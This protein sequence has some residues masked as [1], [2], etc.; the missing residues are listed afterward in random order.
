MPFQNVRGGRYEFAT[1]V[2]PRHRLATAFA[3]SR[4]PSDPA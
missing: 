4:S 1:D 3:D 2:N